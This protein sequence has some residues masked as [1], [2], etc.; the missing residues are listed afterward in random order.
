MQADEERNIKESI[1][2]NLEYARERQPVRWEVYIRHI[3]YL[4]N[5]IQR[6]EEQMK[7]ITG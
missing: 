4:T 6:L 2:T 5:K 3:K 1:Q 7:T